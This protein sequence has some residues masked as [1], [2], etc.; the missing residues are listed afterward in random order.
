MAIAL[1]KG[2]LVIDGGVILS[3]ISRLAD[4]NKINNRYVKDKILIN[5]KGRTP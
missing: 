3:T 5:S 4:L 1:A 2:Y